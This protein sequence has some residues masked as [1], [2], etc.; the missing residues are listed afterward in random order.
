MRAARPLVFAAM[1][2]L[3]SGSATYAS[4]QAHAAPHQLTRCNGFN[5]LDKLAATN[6]ELHARVIAKAAALKNGD[7]L[8]WKIERAGKPT[9]YLLG[10]VHLTDTRIAQLSPAQKTAI[11]GAKT[12]L[13]ENAA[14]PTGPTMR[15]N[16][17]V[18]D[19]AMYDTGGSLDAVLTSEEFEKVR[20]ATGGM[21][22]EILRRHRPWF[23]SLMLS[24]SACERRRIAKG[25]R[26]LDMVI[27][28]EA[29][30]HNIPIEGLE[31]TEQQILALS[32]VP[33]SDQLAMLRAAIA[34]IDDSENL[35]ETMVQLYM[36]R[37]MGALWELQIALAEKEGIAANAFAAFEKSLVTDRNHRMTKAALPYLEE[38][39]FIAVGALHLPG[40][41][42]LVELLRN[43]G[44]E[45]TP[46]E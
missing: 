44:Y 4:A 24:A 13:I 38:G 45:V 15:S 14:K 43:A 8:Y 39:A 46:V 3:L 12:L 37:Q 19:T 16:S 11:D 18:L 21:P 22:P 2:G 40:D 10:T 5:L 31:T 25:Y 42:G 23:V 27:T 33:D 30:A 20:Q 34:L 36:K 17:S 7:T 9:S 28:E 35:R 1:V 32:S 29:N 26:V 6:P 41:E